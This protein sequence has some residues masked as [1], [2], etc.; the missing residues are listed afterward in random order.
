MTVVSHHLNNQQSSFTACCLKGQVCL[1]RYMVFGSA[2]PRLLINQL[3]HD[4]APQEPLFEQSE[5]ASV[6]HS[7]AEVVSQLSPH[8]QLLQ[9]ALGSL[10]EPEGPEQPM[11]A[12]DTSGSAHAFQLCAH[13]ADGDTLIQ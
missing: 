4:A 10:L 3:M 12:G 11:T 7:L 13:V 5:A 8:H 9:E 1:S 6:T 2:T